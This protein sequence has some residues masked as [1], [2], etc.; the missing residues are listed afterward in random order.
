M[1]STTGSTASRWLGFAA[2][3]MWIGVP[4]RLL[5]V[6]GR[7]DVVLHVAGALRHVRVELALELAE[8]LRVRLADDVGEHVEPAAVRHAHHDFVHAVVGRR[9]EQEREHRDQRLRA[10]EAEALLAEELRVQEPLERLGRVEPAEDL[11]LVVVV[12]LG[13]RALDVLLDPVL[14]IGLLDVHV[15]DADRARVRV[16]QHA[17]DVAEL[18]HRLAGEPAGGELAVEVPDRE[19]PVDRVELGVRVRLLQAE[20]I[21]VRD[22]VAAHAVHVHELLHRDDLLE[23]LRPNPATGRWSCDQRAGS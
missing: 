20:R 5:N 10:F 15:L 12:D 19:A 17:E 4:D 21:E 6:A 7:A 23:A 14:L 11:D 1:P 13:V 9:V 8:D 3:V 2:S 18:H 16:A 22:Q